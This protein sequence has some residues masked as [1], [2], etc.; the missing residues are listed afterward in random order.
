MT[1]PFN[2]QAR[3][4]QPVSLPYDQSVQLSNL[5]LMTAR[6]DCEKVYHILKSGGLYVIVKD[7]Y[8]NIPKFKQQPNMLNSCNNWF[9][10]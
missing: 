6:V 7:T 1:D 2:G 3:S 4:V 8:I 5:Y 9:K 10:A